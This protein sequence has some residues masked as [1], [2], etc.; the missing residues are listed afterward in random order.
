MQNPAD[1][2]SFY[3][4][5]ADSF[6]NCEQQVGCIE[7]HYT[8]ADNP[9]RI[10]SAASPEATSHYLQA[11][12]HLQTEPAEGAITFHLLEQTSR[13]PYLL[14][15]LLDVLAKYWHTY[16]DTRG[17]IKGFQSPFCRAVFHAGPNLLSVYFPERKAGFF[18]APDFTKVPN[19]ELA[20]PLRTLLSLSLPAHQQFVHGSA[21]GDA[22]SCVLLT[23]LSGGGKSTTSLLCLRAGFTYLSDDYCV[24][25]LGQ[26]P[27]LHSAYSAAKLKGN[28]DFKRFSDFLPY[29]RYR[30]KKEQ[31]DYA[32]L[33]LY[34]AFAPQI[35]A[36]RPLRAIL[37]PRIT[38]EPNTKIIPIT[39]GLALAALAPTSLFQLPTAGQSALARM[40]ALVRSVPTYALELGSDF[41]SIPNRLRSL[42]SKFHGTPTQN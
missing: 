26:P 1:W 10:L 23:A 31:G 11:F 41:D 30:E 7:T 24:L 21:I 4:L 20:S 28:E 19:Y 8:I 15:F 16:L 12:A 18:C 25:S 29:I 37:V 36:S 33:C 35:V 6:K 14:T 13:I 3:Q 17:E 32:L 39:A 9:Y 40:S 5:L 38:G 2:Q 22:Q 34:P 27:I 42:L